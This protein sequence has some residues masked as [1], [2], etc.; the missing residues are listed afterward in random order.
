M[1][2][3]TGPRDSGGRREATV[4]TAGGLNFKPTTLGSAR[5]LTAGRPAARTRSSYRLQASQMKRG[6][7]LVHYW[8]CARV[9]APHVLLDVG[10]GGVRVGCEDSDADS[11]DSD[12]E[13]RGEGIGEDGGRRDGSRK[14]ARGL[15]R[16]APSVP[17][18]VSTSENIDMAPSYSG[19]CSCQ[20]LGSIR[21]RESG[22]VATLEPTPSSTCCACA[23][24]PRVCWEPARGPIWSLCRNC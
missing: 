3:W 12:R 10:G 1:Q 17:K 19:K 6:F 2:P 18:G 5:C 20:H 14:R 8:G 15:S 9:I 21:V 4:A 22:T 13:G 24:A 23:R 7:V 11:D 16:P